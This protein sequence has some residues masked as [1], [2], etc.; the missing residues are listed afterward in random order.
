MMA[1]VVSLLYTEGQ[2]NKLH[3]SALI[4]PADLPLDDPTFRAM[5]T[6]YIGS[7]F[8]SV[9]SADIVGAADSKAKQI[10]RKFDS[11]YQKLRYAQCLATATFLYNFGG[12]NQ[13]TRGANEAEL[14]LAVTRPDSPPIFGEVLGRFARR[15]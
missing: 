4:L 1:Q 11:E 3:P 7:E 14:R 5:L 9:I 2:A 15:M 10:D 12:G 8:E 6:R 13:Q